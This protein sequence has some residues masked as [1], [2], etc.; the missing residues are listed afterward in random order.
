[1]GLKENIKQKRLEKEMTLEE[2]AS[3]VG[4][5]RQTIQ[6]YESG[7]ISNI[8][9]DKIELMAKALYT[10]PSYLMGWTDDPHDW[11]RI[12]NEAGVHPPKD[13]NGSYEDY[14]KFK[15]YEEQDAL[16]DSYYDSHPDEDINEPFRDELSPETRATAR[17]MMELSPDIRAAARGMMELS[18]EDQK[19]AIDMI[20]YLSQKGKEAKKD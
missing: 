15:M 2:L 6:R 19:T 9:S 14:V 3:K 11:E 13:Y 17:T 5:S 10:T 20:K 12:G 16:I 18:P 4:V 8:P 7:T 1:M